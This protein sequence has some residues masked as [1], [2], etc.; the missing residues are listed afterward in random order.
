[1]PAED[2]WG[3]KRSPTAVL[4]KESGIPPLDLDVQAATLRYGAA[5]QLKPVTVDI[6]RHVKSLWNY[7]VRNSP[8]FDGPRRDRT[9]MEIIR[10]EAEAKVAEA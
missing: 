1:M 4:E 5:T 3:Y 2:Y 6:L 7:C 8:T 9:S 10:R